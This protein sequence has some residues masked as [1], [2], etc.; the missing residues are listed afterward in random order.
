[1]KICGIYK[2]TSPENRI[3]IGQAVDWDRRKYR[4]SVLD[5]KRQTRLYRSLLKHGVSSHIFELI[6]ECNKE[7][8]NDLEI[9]YIKFYN[10]YNSINGLNLSSGGNSK[11]EFSEETRKKMSLSAK[12]KIISEETRKKLSDKGKCRKLSKEH[13][14]KLINCNKG[15]VLTEEQKKYISERTKL[16]MALPEIKEKMSKA[17]RGRIYSKETIDKRRLSMLG[18]NKGWK[19]TL[20]AKEKM[21]L[22]RKGKPAWN[23]GLKGVFI[24]CNKGIKHSQD[25]K[26]K[27]SKANKGRKHTDEELKKMS[28]ASKGRKLSEEH[29]NKIRES[30]KKRL[31]N[32]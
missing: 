25:T 8:L 9:Y 5:C 18:K 23:K 17:S 13:I 7:Q 4:Y 24:A 1:M 3:Y 20:E 14:K 15:R 22:L 28:L 6:H 21:S 11:I 27:I 2:I 29:K 10:S 26:D 12:G 32:G 19:H 16:K 31:L 30:H